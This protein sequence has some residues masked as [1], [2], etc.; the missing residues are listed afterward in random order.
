MV[1]C[2]ASAALTSAGNHRP[3]CI[4]GHDTAHGATKGRQKVVSDMVPFAA[5]IVLTSAGNYRPVCIIGHDTARG[6][7]SGQQ[8]VV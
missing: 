5:P 2:A 6:A 8:Q 1:P 3:A 4:I 7:T